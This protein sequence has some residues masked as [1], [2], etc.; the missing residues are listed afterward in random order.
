MESLSEES[1]YHLA[2]ELPAPQE[3]NQAAENPPQVEQSHPQNQNL[4][5]LCQKLSSV[6]DE[7][8]KPDLRDSEFV[9]KA[10]VN[11]VSTGVF[12][13]DMDSYCFQFSMFMWSFFIHFLF[14]SGVGILLFLC[15]WRYS[16]LT[17]NHFRYSD[18]INLV[19]FGLGGFAFIFM[20]TKGYNN[21]DIRFCVIYHIQMMLVCSFACAAVESYCH[22]KFIYILKNFKLTP[23]SFE[24]SRFR[25]DTFWKLIMRDGVKTRSFN[26]LKHN[27]LS[28]GVTDEEERRKE[29]D[30]LQKDWDQQREFRINCAIQNS[31][32]KLD[33]DISLFYLTFFGKTP[34][35]LLRVM[36]NKNELSLEEDRNQ[37]TSSSKMPKSELLTAIT[38][39]EHNLFNYKY[40]TEPN[41]Y[42]KEKA[43]AYTLASDL[44]RRVDKSDNIFGFTKIVCS[45]I[46]SYAVVLFSFN[47]N[48]ETE[49]WWFSLV[50][51][52]VQPSY[53]CLLYFIY[54]AVLLMK[55]KSTLMEEL[56]QLMFTTKKN[57]A[58]ERPYPIINF[59]DFMSLK[60]WT[61]L[62]K[63]FM[64]LNNEKLKGTIL[65][66]SIILVINLLTL[67]VVAIYY[68]GLWKSADSYKKLFIV[69]TLNALLY[70]TVLLAL[71]YYAAKVNAQ[72]QVH[73]NLIRSIKQ[74]V[75][76]LFKLYPDFVGENAIKPGTYI[77]NVGLK[78]LKEEFGYDLS[79]Q[80]KEKMK[81]K[82]RTLM[83]NYDSILEELDYEETNHPI[84]ILGLPIT[85]TVVKSFAA[86]L[87]SI[88]T[89][90]IK[91]G[92]ASLSSLGGEK[93]S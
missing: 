16:T 64:H 91:Q 48:K 42:D 62:R 56:E 39:F 32:S 75:T 25:L 76:M 24:M 86:M 55:S 49:W 36:I 83:E 34:Q 77:Y 79:D 23:E 41:K 66:V 12:E 85:M 9:N 61:C 19:Y 17:R 52:S 10:R 50:P 18:Q 60:S 81:E 71:I 89:P 68:F 8:D 78:L 43:H 63:I 21:M 47:G 6:K 15:L 54:K 14:L 5:L 84:K 20:L 35:N 88:V 44:L 74:T 51:F 3:P 57:N 7:E 93:T 80:T 65:A 31:I 59:L 73:K 11:Q 70:L 45:M 1:Y 27:L 72:F 67:G 26:Q 53:Y 82:E 92:I 4:I 40:L 38:L 90:L 33:I 58:R 22:E 69:F 13:V 2:L 28:K 87:I 46:L 29:M 30:K 37:I